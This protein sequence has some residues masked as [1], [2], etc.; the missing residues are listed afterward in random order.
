MTL[1]IALSHLSVPPME[2][3]VV[4]VVQRQIMLKMREDVEFVPNTPAHVGLPKHGPKIPL[5]SRKC[6]KY[7]H[8][9]D[10]KRIRSTLT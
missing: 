6:Q 2:A 9:Q 10:G 5:K 7:N 4:Y 1:M 3:N 8:L